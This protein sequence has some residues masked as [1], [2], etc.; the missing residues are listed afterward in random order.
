MM[1]VTPMV[2]FVSANSPYAT[3]GDL[4]AALKKDATAA[5]PVCGGQLTRA[6]VPPKRHLAYVR[7]RS[8]ILCSECGRSTVIDRGELEAG[9]Q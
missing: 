1:V 7:A 3:L 2:F 4:I 6:A 9:N 8:W 5:C